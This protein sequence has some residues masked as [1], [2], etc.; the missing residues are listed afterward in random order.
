MYSSQGNRALGTFKRINTMTVQTSAPKTVSVIIVG[1]TKVLI[2][3]T[4]KQLL[5]R[6]VDFKEGR[7]HVQFKDQFGNKVVRTYLPSTVKVLS[8]KA[9][10][11][12][13]KSG[14]FK[15]NF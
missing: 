13:T 15:I 9:V 4:C 11:K 5:G 1:K 7:Y 8:G 3:Y 6:V 14:A 10:K 12:F 2:P